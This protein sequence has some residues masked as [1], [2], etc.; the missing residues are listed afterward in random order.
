MYTYSA[1]TELPN[2]LSQMAGC[3]EHLVTALLRKSPPQTQL[4][5]RMLR[6]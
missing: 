6:V 5:L 2:A 1:H 3:L 4:Q